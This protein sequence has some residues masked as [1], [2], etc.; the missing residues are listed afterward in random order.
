MSHNKE[1][2]LVLHQLPEGMGLYP[3]LHPGCL[4]HLLG[5]AAIILNL[6]RILDHCLV[7]APSQGHVNGRPGIFIILA[8]AVTVHTDTDT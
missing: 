7:A 6:I 3:G 2:V 1:P 5:L 8:V 4:L